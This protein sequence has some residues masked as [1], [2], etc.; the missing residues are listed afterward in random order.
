MASTPVSAMALTSSACSSIDS[1]Q[2][3]DATTLMRP[4]EA[5][6]I[7][8]AGSTR[9]TFPAGGFLQQGSPAESC[10]RYFSAKYSAKS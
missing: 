7:V 8:R 5:F 2:C 3:P 10:G 9:K 4:A 6:T 1:E